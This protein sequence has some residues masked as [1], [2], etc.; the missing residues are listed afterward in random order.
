MYFHSHE[1]N[2]SIPNYIFTETARVSLPAKYDM[3]NAITVCDAMGKIKIG[4]LLCS[5]NPE[6]YMRPESEMVS[7]TLYRVNGGTRSLSDLTGIR[8]SDL[9][10]HNRAPITTSLLKVKLYQ[11]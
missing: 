6:L 2:F 9:L 7:V 11:C 5:P 10:H 3:N 1:Y 8:T 4:S